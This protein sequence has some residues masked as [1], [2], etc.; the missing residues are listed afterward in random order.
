ML[1]IGIVNIAKAE[2]CYLLGLFTCRFNRK[3]A[4]EVELL[5]DHSYCNTCVNKEIL[6]SNLFLLQ[7]SQKN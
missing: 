7:F 5:R 3:R 4:W 2:L 6:G 1:L